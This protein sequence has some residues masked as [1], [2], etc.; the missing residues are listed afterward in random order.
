MIPVVEVVMRDAVPLLGALTMDRED[1]FTL[2]APPATNV[3]T[4]NWL[5]RGRLG[6]PAVEDGTYAPIPFAMVGAEAA[7]A[8]EAATAMVVPT[9]RH[10]ATA[11]AK[12]LPTVEVN[13]PTGIGA[14]FSLP[15]PLLGRT[16]GR[17]VLP[18]RTAAQPFVPTGS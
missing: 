12:R 6:L 15:C 9:R 11:A 7:W 13:S 1:V 17:R 14:S 8:G 5:A 16:G 2:D 10:A 18:G 3:R 4:S